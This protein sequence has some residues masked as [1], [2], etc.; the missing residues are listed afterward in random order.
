MHANIDMD[1][2]RHAA[3]A[4]QRSSKRFML[5]NLHVRPTILYLKAETVAVR[6]DHKNAHAADEIAW[7]QIL[8]SCN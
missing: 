7:T 8:R 4:A 3:G 5:S 1:P 2:K 6:A